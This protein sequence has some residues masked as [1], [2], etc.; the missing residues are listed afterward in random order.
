MLC[1]Q[2]LEETAK[3]TDWQKERMLRN[4]T[5]RVAARVQSAE[6]EDGTPR[7]AQSV[8]VVYTTL[9]RG[10][11]ARAQEV[12]RVLNN[13]VYSVLTSHDFTLGWL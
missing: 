1:C 4:R 10:N 2:A 8:V 7:A 13:Y 5:L 3:E 9:T 12:G 11:M 6:M